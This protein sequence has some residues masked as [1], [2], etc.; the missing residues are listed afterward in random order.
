MAQQPDLRTRQR[1]PQR[2][3]IYTGENLF[4]LDQSRIPPGMAYTWKRV[5]LLG[6]EDKENQ[7]I[8]EMN[9]WTPVPA[10]RHPEL[11]G[12]S[13][14]EGPIV[15]KG[16]MLMEQPKEWEEE[17]RALQDFRAANTLEE[18]VQRMGKSAKREGGRGVKRTTEKVTEF[19]E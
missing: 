1:A 19:V 4:D 9:G 5:S 13:G 7:I 10:N 14:G 2:R 18:Q 15:R 16:L 6:Q 12:K 3:R 17:S 8:A 11:A